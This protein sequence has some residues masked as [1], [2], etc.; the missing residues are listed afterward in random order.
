M[1]R[2]TVTVERGIISAGADVDTYLIDPWRVEAG[3]AIT[4]SDIGS[5]RVHLLDGLEIT[6]S[7]VASTALELTLSNGATVT[8]LDAQ[9]Y[10]VETGGNPL[11]GTRGVEYDFESFT[12]AIL[13]V[14]VPGSGI[15]TGGSAS[16]TDAGA[17]EASTDLPIVPVELRGTSGNDTLEGG[18]GDDAIFGGDGNDVLFGGDGNDVLVGE[19]GN[20]LLVGGAG[21]DTLWSTSGF[22]TL[23]GGPGAD[24]FIVWDY[25]FD[26]F[27]TIVDLGAEDTLYPL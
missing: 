5:N 18:G 21:N 12:R 8:I 10:T 16:V 4:I 20:D 2:D 11:F 3:A 6:A 22:D 25:Y 1:T 27:V 23:A 13:G 14:A 17:L 7:R 9:N 26:G 24:T 19:G 15:A